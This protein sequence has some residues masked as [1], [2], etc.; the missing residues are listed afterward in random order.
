[1]FEILRRSWQI[2]HLWDPAQIVA[3]SEDVWDPA[4]VVADSPS[5][6]SC[7]HGGRFWGC[8]KSCADRGR[9]TICGILRKSWQ[10]L[11][12]SEILRRPWQI[13]PNAVC[14]PQHWHIPPIRLPDAGLGQDHAHLASESV[15]VAEPTP[16]GKGT[17]IHWPKRQ[18]HAWYCTCQTDSCWNHDPVY[19]K[20]KPSINDVLF[21]VFGYAVCSRKIKNALHEHSNS[22]ARIAKNCVVALRFF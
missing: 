8:L 20:L 19:P 14:L 21:D 13:H 17:W 10:I 6:G 11:R 4:H 15:A 18:K 5:V 12:M 7:A 2:H 3:D 9:F 16:N 22:K 1:M